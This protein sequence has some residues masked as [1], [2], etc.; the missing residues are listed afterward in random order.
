MIEVDQLREAVSH[1][2]LPHKAELAV[3]ILDSLDEAHYGV[4]DEEVLNCWMKMESRQV[5]GLTLAEFKTA[6]GRRSA[7]I[8]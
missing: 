6:C 1:L 8:H 7:F 2:F 3:Y 5:E 4:S